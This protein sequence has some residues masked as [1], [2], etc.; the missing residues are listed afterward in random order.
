M[1]AQLIRS[2]L[3]AGCFFIAACA[4]QSGPDESAP[5]PDA[6]ELSENPLDVTELPQP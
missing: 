3:L 1:S 4:T 6:R 2:F 5:L